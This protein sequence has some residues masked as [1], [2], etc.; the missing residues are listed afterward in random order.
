MIPDRVPK[1]AIP[2]AVTALAIFAGYWALVSV[3][4]GHY[5]QAAWLIVLA[6]FFD[7]LD[8]YVARLLNATSG[9]GVQFDSLA[10]IVN[11][12]V[13]PAIL[14]YAVYFDRWGAFG[15]LLSFSLVLSAAVRLARFNLRLDQDGPQ[16]KATFDGLPTTMAAFLLSGYLIFAGEVTADFGQPVWSLVVTLA[17]AFLMVSNVPYDKD[18]ILIPRIRNRFQRLTMGVII[19]PFLVLFPSVAV[20]GL[21]LLYVIWAPV[22]GIALS[23]KGRL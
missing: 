8:G 4:Q 12:G 20:F 16:A 23:V 5:V 9:F 7:F 6:A 17:V 14:Y 18:S 3:L 1:A 15:M 2:N 11:Y 19:L 10:D 22:N 13:V 21:G